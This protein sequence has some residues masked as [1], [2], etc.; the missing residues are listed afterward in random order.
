MN[1]LKI[2]PEASLTQV[3]AFKQQARASKITAFVVAMLGIGLM[4]A[5]FVCLGIATH[6]NMHHIGMGM[7]PAIGGSLLL[8]TSGAFL[9]ASMA[10]TALA[11]CRSRALTHHLNQTAFEAQS[12]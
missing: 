7:F 11:A 12:V 3:S 1:C 10:T 4:S 8:L 2:S 6:P 5:S 9:V